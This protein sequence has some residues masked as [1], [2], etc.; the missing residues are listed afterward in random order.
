MDTVQRVT[1]ERESPS[2]R[3]INRQPISPLRRPFRPCEPPLRSITILFSN[4]LLVMC[5][6]SIA[7][8]HVGRQ[9]S[10]G[11]S[12]QYYSAVLESSVSILLVAEV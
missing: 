12:V 8:H 11:L 9:F 5:S 4:S 7:D 10:N 2:G 6:E 3:H 1:R